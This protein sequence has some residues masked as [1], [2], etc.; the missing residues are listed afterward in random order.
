MT[1]V[2]LLQ[3]PMTYSTEDLVSFYIE[4]AE[5]DIEAHYFS[6]DKS[7]SEFLTHCVYQTYVSS[8]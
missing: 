6:H 2:S 8:T 1:R 4:K 3:L 7:A 5:P